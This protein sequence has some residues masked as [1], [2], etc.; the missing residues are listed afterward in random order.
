MLQSIAVSIEGTVGGLWYNLS[1]HYIYFIN[2]SEILS[3]SKSKH[4]SFCLLLW[5]ATGIDQ[6]HTL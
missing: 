2:L 5:K 3:V 1:I 6:R 4:C